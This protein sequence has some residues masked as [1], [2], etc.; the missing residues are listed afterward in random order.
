MA[1]PTDDFGA[2]RRS[3]LCSCTHSQ[4]ILFPRP[5][6]KEAQ[7]KRKRTHIKPTLTQVIA[8]R[9][10]RAVCMQPLAYSRSRPATLGLFMTIHKMVEWCD[11]STS[12]Q[13]KQMTFSTYDFPI[14]SLCALLFSNTLGKRLT[15]K[16]LY[17]LTTDDHS[18]QATS[19]RSVQAKPRI[20]VCC[21]FL[22]VK[23]SRRL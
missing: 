11:T 17:F 3:F 21:C 13:T 7:L 18:K 14:C 2:T 15:A 1:H 23:Y 22:C 10:L 8:F 20:F 6:S 12:T 4:L 16:K 5:G 9:S 19:I